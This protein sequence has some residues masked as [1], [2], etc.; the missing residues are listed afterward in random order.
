MKFQVQI[1]VS[2]S[3]GIYNKNISVKTFGYG[4]IFTGLHDTNPKP[5]TMNA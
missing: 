1:S 3:H 5:K 4:K 2:I